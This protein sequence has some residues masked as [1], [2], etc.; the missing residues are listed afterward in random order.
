MIE[1]FEER[2]E[3]LRMGVPETGAELEQWIE[4]GALKGGQNM[5]GDGEF[6]TAVAED[7]TPAG[8]AMVFYLGYDG[9]FREI[10]I[11]FFPAANVRMADSLDEM[12][13]G[14]PHVQ[15]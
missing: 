3:R 14:I 15:S 1:S 9:A 6:W 10:E 2:F 11:M 5:D 4:S 7:G 8:A 12:L 13:K